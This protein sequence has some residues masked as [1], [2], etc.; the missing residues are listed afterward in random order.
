MIGIREEIVIVKPSNLLELEVLLITINIIVVSRL[1]ITFAR[2]GLE[3]LGDL[4]DAKTLLTS[5][6]EV[7]ELTVSIEYNDEAIRDFHEALR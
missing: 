1:L 4:G 6:S 3:V 7:R 5:R 2:D